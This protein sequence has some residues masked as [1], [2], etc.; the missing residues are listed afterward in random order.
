M[1]GIGFAVPRPAQGANEKETASRC[2]EAFAAFEAVGL[3][4][5]NL[6]TCCRSLRESP[7]Q[8]PVPKSFHP[9][10]RNSKELNNVL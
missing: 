9:E 5:S 2:A 6:W 8:R 3:K 1:D 7:L 10:D 4:G